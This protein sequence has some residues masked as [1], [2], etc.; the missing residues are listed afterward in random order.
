MVTIE[1]T[2]EWLL[3]EAVVRF[4]DAM[5]Y[6]R[7]FFLYARGPGLIMKFFFLRYSSYIFFFDDMMN[8]IS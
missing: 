6:L 5:L 4:L 3:V 7:R 1:G 8:C 2:R